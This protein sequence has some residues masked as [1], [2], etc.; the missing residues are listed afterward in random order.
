MLTCKSS[1]SFWQACGVFELTCNETETCDWFLV[2]VWKWESLRWCSCPANHI[3]ACL[4]HIWQ[5]HWDELSCWWTWSQ[6]PG[7]EWGREKKEERR[8]KGGEEQGGD[9]GGGGKEGR[10]RREGK[11]EEEEE[12]DRGKEDIIYHV[13]TS[14]CTYTCLE[15]S[16][17]NF[18]N[19]I[20][21]S[22]ACK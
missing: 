3:A 13:H 2:A 10:R 14:R 11:D 8:K 22:H 19:L 6:H 17:M 18:C 9:E 16:T 5:H 7:V 4:R 1:Q 15:S 21:Q 12:E 20:G